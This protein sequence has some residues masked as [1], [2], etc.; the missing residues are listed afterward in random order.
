VGI[1]TASAR[2]SALPTHARVF[3]M[4]LDVIRIPASAQWVLL[5]IVAGFCSTLSA[6]VIT[7]PA[8]RSIRLEYEQGAVEKAFILLGNVTL[9]GVSTV[10]GILAAGQGPVAVV[11]PLQV[12]AT[13][14]SNMIIQSR[15]G[16]ARYTKN[17]TVGTLV[18]AAAVM[19]LPDLGP[20]QLPPDINALELL[21]ANLSMGFI[22]FCLFVMVFGL[23]LLVQAQTQGANLLNNNTTMLFTYALVGGIG[24]VLN[25]SIAKV[26]QMHL[27]L[28]VK[29]PLVSLYVFLAC[30]CLGVAAM[31]N[32]TLDD[33]ILFVPISNGVNLVLNCLAG[34]CIWGDW[35]RLDCPFGYCIVYVLVVLG[36]YLVSSLDFLFMN[37]LDVAEEKVNKVK[38]AWRQT[39][40][41]ITVHSPP[42]QVDQPRDCSRIVESLCLFCG[43]TPKSSIDVEDIDYPFMVHNRT[44]SLGDLFANQYDEETDIPREKLYAC[45]LRALNNGS[46][47]NDAIVELCLELA[48]ENGTQGVYRTPVFTRWVDVHIQEGMPTIQSASFRASRPYLVG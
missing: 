11:F 9:T 20:E 45:L 46:V 30:F 2:R 25:T 40:T 38:Q 3:T 23:R 8:N 28:V 24:T 6:V 35:K 39:K 27:S 43:C 21:Q 22:A 32:G 41:F 15:L 16:I 18:L 13:L 42:V 19:L 26:V 36:T 14:L 44:K 48:Q 17:M 47:N 29:V 33:P 1:E 4:F 7:Y 37:Y 34:L 12:G 31:A 10:L 5:A